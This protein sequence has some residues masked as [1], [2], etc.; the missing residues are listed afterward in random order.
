MIKPLVQI[1][2]PPLFFAV[3]VTNLQH[4]SSHSPVYAFLTPSGQ[5]GWAFLLDLSAPQTKHMRDSGNYR[6]LHLTTV[7]S[8]VVERVV[9][10]VLVPFFIRTGAFG[11]T[12]WA[13]QQQMNCTDLVAVQILHW[14]QAIQSS[15]K[16]TVLLND[17]SFAFDSVHKRE[18]VDKT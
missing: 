10:Y 15:K 12:Q 8:K 1:I 4:Q 7:L 11:S 2:F 3:V 13:F 18:T 6:G 17:M 14:L 9:A 5:N 16:T